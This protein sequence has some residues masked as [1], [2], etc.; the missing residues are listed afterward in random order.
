MYKETFKLT[1]YQKLPDYIERKKYVINP[2]TKDASSLIYCILVIKLKD[3]LKSKIEKSTPI[4]VLNA[5]ISHYNL[6]TNSTN[7]I[8]LQELVFRHLL[9]DVY[10]EWQEVEKSSIISKDQLDKICSVTKVN[11]RIIDADIESR[12]R[13]VIYTLYYYDTYEKPEII[14]VTHDEEESIHFAYVQEPKISLNITIQNTFKCKECDGFIRITND[15]YEES[16]KS[17]RKLHD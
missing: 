5:Y 6:S 9:K 15:N 13:K 16:I 14:I 4:K 3:Q 17:H 2:R 12:S 11:L 8:D 7:I 10:E 1:N